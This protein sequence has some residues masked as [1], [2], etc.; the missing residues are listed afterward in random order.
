MP[1]PILEVPTYT[2]VV[3]ST[4]ETIEYRP[5]LV[6]EEK[7]LLMA[8]EGEDPNEM[9]IAMGNIIENCTFEKV[10]SKTLAVFDVEYIFLKIRAKSVGEQSTITIRCQ[11]MIEEQSCDE[12]NEFNLDLSSVEVDVPEQHIKN[13]ELSETMG[14]IMKYP[15]FD[16]YQNREENENAVDSLFNTIYSCIDTVYNNEEVYTA[17]DFTREELSNF[18]DDLNQLQFGKINDFFSS[19][20]SLSQDLDFKCKKCGYNDTITL[21]SVDDFFG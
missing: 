1:L 11:N 10:N 6:K 18:L 19:L 3:P 2:L 4:G 21:Q 7:I 5:F 12:P 15:Q 8:L 17:D 14:I 9:Y 13:I 20:P 16:S